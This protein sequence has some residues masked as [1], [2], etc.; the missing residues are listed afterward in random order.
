[1]SLREQGGESKRYLKDCFFF[2]FIFLDRFST[3]W[4][5]L[6]SRFV[7]KDEP[8]HEPTRPRPPVAHLYQR[9]PWSHSL[10]PEPIHSQAGLS[11]VPTMA[12]GGQDALPPPSARRPWS[13]QVLEGFREKASHVR[14][15]Y[16][17]QDYI[18]S[19]ARSRLERNGTVDQGHATGCENIVRNRQ[20]FN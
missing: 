9:D 12:T 20:T 19:V 17:W 16:Y 8:G 3:C 4:S 5:S 15:T 6:P 14:R 10:V 18:A 13:L 7:S 2:P 1:L 11:S